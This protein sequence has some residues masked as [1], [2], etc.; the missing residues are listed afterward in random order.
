MTNKRSGTCHFRVMTIA[1][2]Y[3]AILYSGTVAALPNPQ[4][5]IDY[6]QQNYNALTD[7]DDPRV[8]NAQRIFGRILQAAGT[9][10]GVIPRL[11][12]IR[13]NPFNVVLPISIPDGWIILSRQVLDMC[14]ENRQQGDDRLAFVLAHEIAHLL[15][16]DF[17]HMNFF[18][19][20]SLLQENRNAEQQKVVNEI[21]DIFTHTAKIEAKELRADEKGILFSAMAGYNPFAI[22]NEQAGEQG[23]FF[24]EWHRLLNV[25]QYAQPGPVTTHPTS[26][27][28]STAVLARLKQVSEQSDLFRLGLILYQT[29]KFELAEKAFSEFLRYF[30]SREVY[31]NLAAA[32][33]QIALNHHQSDPELAKQRLLPFYL[34]VMADP[35]TRA[36]FSVS[37]GKPGSQ[38]TFGEHMELAIK[39]YKLAIEQ[40]ANYFLAYQNLAS[41]YL[42]NNEP[43]KAIAVLQDIAAR[44]PDNA[45]LNNILGVG[46]YLTDN[47]DKAAAL[48]KKAIAIDDL[49]APAYYN[50]GKVAY[51]QGD[52]N[53]A[54]TFWR[55]FIAIAPEHRWS[56]HLAANFN[57]PDS[58]APKQKVKSTLSKQPEALAG[59]KVGLYLDELPASLGEPRVK[60]FML[61][62]SEYLLLEYP[63]GISIVA[64]G[65][66]IKIINASEKYPAAQAQGVRIGSSRN[67]VISSYGLPELQLDATG[68]KNL[69]YPREG[70][71]F[72]LADDKVVS[73]SIY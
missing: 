38:S 20:L 48:L 60:K 47:V 12:I 71:S 29:G 10:Y 68:G 21:Q 56:Q 73:W 30:P 43:Y 23:S 13:E 4:E 66:E 33:H 64:E 31:H 34:P 32:H 27:Q 18:S 40:D 55:K 3:M 69:L 2:G 17:W 50:M 61:S 8:G 22:V 19:A 6:W 42:V 16:D 26:S 53:Q 51:L 25:A 15:D 72:Q 28:R 58:A 41:A 54:K 9:R 44:L 62:E 70:V 57:F 65:D 59:V 46:F 1:V 67:H 11:H 39:N 45:N 14:Y 63:S 35:Y 36:A 5:R 7:A 37:R 24:H 49:Y 52:R